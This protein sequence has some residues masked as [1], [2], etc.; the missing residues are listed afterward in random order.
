MLRIYTASKSYMAPAWQR[1]REQLVDVEITSRWIDQEHSTDSQVLEKRARENQQDIARADMV[2]VYGGEEDRLS[3]TLVAVGRALQAGKTVICVGT[4]PSF[5][6]WTYDKNVHF[7]ES[8]LAAV[9]LG[10]KLFG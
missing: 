6:D 5:T 8:P 9:E 7:A 4:S 3:E 10:R 1:F 2:L